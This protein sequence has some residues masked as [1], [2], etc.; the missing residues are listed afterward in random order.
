M[1]RL[2]WASRFLT[3]RSYEWIA[4]LCR[5]YS[6]LPDTWC[7]WWLE[8]RVPGYAYDNMVSSPAAEED[9]GEWVQE[10]K[11]YVPVSTALEIEAFKV[12]VTRAVDPLQLFRRPLPDVSPLI[13]FVMGC[14]L[15]YK[16]EVEH[17]RGQAERQL[18]ELPWYRNSL[19]KMRDCLPEVTYETD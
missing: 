18:R 14:H 10:Q 2:A 1:D 17:L 6:V 5:T 19:D 13:V 9:F 7:R 16:D 4:S 11:E 12:E 15:G 3:E 8:T